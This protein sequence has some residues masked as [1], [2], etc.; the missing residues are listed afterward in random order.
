MQDSDLAFQSL[1]E[2]A[3]RLNPQVRLHWRHLGD[4]WVV[5]EVLSGL[6]HHLA[7]LPAAVLMG[8]EPGLPLTWRDLLAHLRDEFGIA[9]DTPAQA[10][11]HAMLDQFVALGL[12]LPCAA[13]PITPATRP[14]THAA[15]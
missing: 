7:H 8:F 9:F 15:V 13:V 11:L 14:G 10:S 4:A 5:F 12:I 2:A 6:T 1:V 3:W